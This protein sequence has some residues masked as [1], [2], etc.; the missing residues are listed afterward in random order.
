MILSVMSIFH[1]GNLATADEGTITGAPISE[2]VR[3]A[4]KCVHFGVF[5][6]K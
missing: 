6:K 5:I 2:N 1:G 3:N 4:S